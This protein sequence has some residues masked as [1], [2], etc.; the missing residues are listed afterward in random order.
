MAERVWIGCSGWQYAS[1]RGGAFY[2]E[3]L[4]QR[5]WLGHY[6]SVFDTVELNNTFYRLPKV[7]AVQR[8]AD[9]SPDSFLFT[10]K[11]SQYAT[12]MK[13]LTTVAESSG[14]LGERCAS[15][16]SGRPSGSG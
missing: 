5:R 7:E 2:P 12:H 16:R 13:R 15:G 14:M 10:V 4:A 3:R 1:W 11:V 6:A 9:E 8:W